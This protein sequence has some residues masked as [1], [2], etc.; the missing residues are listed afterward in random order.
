[1]GRD[2]VRY[3]LFDLHWQWW[4]GRDEGQPRQKM[5]EELNRD[6]AQDNSEARILSLEDKQ[7]DYT[8]KA[9]T[10]YPAAGN[11]R[12]LLIELEREAKAQIYSSGSFAPAPAAPPQ[13]GHAERE[14]LEKGIQESE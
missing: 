10:V 12:D 3:T 14:M 4:T 8:I 11:E 7:R 5:V 13:K 9:A 6:I 1:K 2:L